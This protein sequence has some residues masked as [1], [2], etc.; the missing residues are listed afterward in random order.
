MTITHRLTTAAVLALALA[1]GASSLATAMPNRSAPG[2]GQV[3][4]S[5][6]ASTRANVAA[7][8]ASAPQSTP[9]A[10]VRVIPSTN[11]FDWGDAG[12]GAAG[13]LAIA[14]VGLGGGLA[15]SQRHRHHTAA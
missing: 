12:I 4:L 2:G 13:G 6:A 14:L 3:V 9:A 7:A 1:A 8:R 5:P 11:G 10:I 15:V